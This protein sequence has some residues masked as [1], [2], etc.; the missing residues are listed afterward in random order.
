MSFYDAIRVGASGAADFEV[1]RSLRFIGE[2]THHYLERTPSS[3]GNRQ[4]CTFSCWTKRSNIGVNHCL[5][6]AYSANNDS[7]NISLVFRSLSSGNCEFRVVG[8]NYNFRITNAAFRD[9]SA[10]LHVV[11]AFDTTQSS[12]DDRVKVYINGV[13]ETSFSTSGNVTQ[14]MNIA[15]NDTSV[16]RIGTQS[17]ALSN[18]ADGYIAEVNFID[19]QQLTPASF[20]ETNADTGQ[21]VP[22]DTS[23]L[24]FGTNGYRLQFEDNSGTT[25]TTLGKDTSGNGNNFTPSNFSVAAGAGNDSVED[26]P[27]NNFPTFNPLCENN[28]HTYSEGNLKVT[29]AAN[30][31]SGST[32]SMATPRT[33]KWYWEVRALDSFLFIGVT[34][35]TYLGTGNVISAANTGGSTVAYYNDGQKYVG[36]SVSSY[37]ASFANG[38]LIGVAVDMDNGQV[39]FYKNNAS[40]GAISLV[41]TRGHIGVGAVGTGQ[42]LSMSINFGQQAFTY[43]PPTGFKKLCSANLPDPTILLPNKHFDTLLWSGNATTSDRSITGLNFQPDWAWTKTRNHAYH[44]ALFDAIRGPANRLNLDQDFVENHTSGGHLASFDA[45]TSG[46]NDGGITWDYGSGNEWWNVSGK[47][48]VAWN[49]NAGDTDSATYTVKVVSDSGNKYRFNDFGTSAVTLDLAEGGTYTFDGSDSS[50]SGH[51]FVIGTAANGSVYS[52]G[53]TYQLDGA[54]V[55]YSAYT[56]GYATATTRKLIITVPASAPQLYYWCSIHSGMGGAINTNSTL[57]SSNFEGNTQATVKA[58]P[59]AGFSIISWTARGN[60]SGTYDTFGHGLGVRPNWL[61]LKSRNQTGNW[62]VYNS[63]FSS[64]NN[65]ILQLSNTIAETTSSNYWGANDTTP[66]STLVNVNQGNYANSA[67]HTFIMYAFSEVEGYSKFGRHNG[68]GSTDG[69][70]VY[71]GFRPAFVM[72]KRINATDHWNVTDNKRGNFNVIDEALYA[73]LDSTEDSNSYNRIDYLSNGFKYRANNSQANESGGQY[74][75]FA[76]AESPFK[77]SRA[78]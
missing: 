35:D 6:S 17:N 50:M 78:R 34:A 51:P 62:N 4:V 76:F 69:T 10:W 60:S 5:A 63:N 13:Q 70:F 25:A 31:Q 39:T 8:Y 42:A 1:K 37:G 47:N 22:I 16:H 77:N 23:G 30:N 18:T 56:S 2:G 29:H 59:T 61:I 57:G 74:V 14:N 68:N 11:V 41:S 12:A 40:Q 58:N 33:G 53:V 24:T 67:S 49:W 73:N 48:Y 46:N 54:S 45:P 38:D 52:T 19:G 9:P 32:T 72:I 44:H 55:S 20:A 36:G 3:A 26:T 28:D 43:T 71:T 65:K 75:Y 27:T 21:W 15:F 66:S 7:D 64:A